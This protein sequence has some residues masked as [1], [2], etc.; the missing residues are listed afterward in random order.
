MTA[1]AATETGLIAIWLSSVLNA[2]TGAGGV[3]TLSTGGIHEEIDPAGGSYPKVIFRYQGGSDLNAPGADRRVFVNA[4]YAVYAV[5]Q[6]AS[7]GGALDALAA[8]IDVLL[9]G[10]Q[11]IP[12]GS[13]LLLGCTRVGPLQIPGLSNGVSIRMLGGIYRC[14]AQ[15]PS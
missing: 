14:F 11:G 9:R 2:D 12:I 6:I 15:Q 13:G 8:R 10:Q 4:L 1:T 3:A 7:Y 5:W